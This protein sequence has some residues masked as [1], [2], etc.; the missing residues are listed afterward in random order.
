MGSKK[1]AAVAAAMGVRDNLEEKDFT[2]KAWEWLGENETLVNSTLAEVSDNAVSRANAKDF[3]RRKMYAL[4]VRMVKDLKGTVKLD[5]AAGTGKPAPKYVVRQQKS[6]KQILKVFGQRIRDYL[7]D[8]AGMPRQGV[9]GSNT[10]P[11]D[12]P[13]WLGD[14]QPMVS[15]IS[16]IL[17]NG[18]NSPASILRHI[19]L[20][21]DKTG[22]LVETEPTGKIMD[23]VKNAREWKERQKQ[24]EN[25]GTE[26]PPAEVI[27][28]DS[29]SVE[30]LL[31]W[32][33]HNRESWGIAEIDALMALL[34]M[35]K[36]RIEEEAKKQAA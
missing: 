10:K 19:G 23:L 5:Y 21:T 14:L 12:I 30:Q 29:C 27:E 36:Q 11:K 31:P 26:T 34:A 22:N 1:D 2:E 13:G 28:P 33:S 17:Q 24:A 3:D 35:E 32:L 15:E 7:A 9:E 20:K 25:Q 18:G 4:A 16:T 8:K 6:A